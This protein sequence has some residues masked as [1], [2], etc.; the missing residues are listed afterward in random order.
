MCKEWYLSNIQINT[1]YARYSILVFD[2][3][4]LN[5]TI[6]GQLLYR[7]KSHYLDFNRIWFSKHDSIEPFDEINNTKEVDLINCD[8]FPLQ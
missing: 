6:K 1:L 7:K 4:F 2:S 5:F 3:Q 8:R